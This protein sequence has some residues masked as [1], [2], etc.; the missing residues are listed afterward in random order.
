[1]TARTR[2]AALAAGLIAFTGFAMTAQSARPVPFG[3]PLRIS[4][5]AAAGDSGNVQFRITNTSK[6]A[7]KIPNWQLPSGQL[8]SDLF[9]VYQN[10]QKID[11]VGKMIKRAPITEADFV[12]LRAGETKLINADLSSVYD[13]TQDGQYSVRFKSYLQ[14]AKTD[15]GQLL[16]SSAGKMALL[17]TAE[18][19]TFVSAAGPTVS[20]LQIAINQSQE[21]AGRAGT[22][23]VT[24]GVNY[25][26]CSS[27]RVTTAGQAVNAARNYSE[28]AKNYLNAGT[29]GP[30]Y[31]TWFGSYTSTRYNGAK[32][33]F[34]KIDTA[35][36]QTGGAITINCGC[37]QSYFAYVYP[38][39]PYQIFVCNAFWSAGLTGTD[40]KGGT[41]VHEMSHFDI[42]G[43]TDDVVYGQSGAKSLAI[44]NPTDAARNADTHEYFSENTPFQN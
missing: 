6:N 25:V 42:V 18:M 30:R 22:K 11:Y 19:R 1:M 29:T 36:D 31:T 24:N 27:S 34:T 9:D 20:D 35:L 16:T 32:S 10:G 7:I 21:K 14:G 8:D 28:N 5:Q 15:K 23:A 40:S 38:N 2:Y 13:M 33:R 3:N 4:I 39:Q 37:N 43:N 44:S 17:Q 12:T 26:G 41:L